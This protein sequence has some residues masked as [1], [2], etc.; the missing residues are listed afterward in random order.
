M[1]A[2]LSIADIRAL[3][4]VKIAVIGQGTQK[5][6]KHFGLKADF[7]PSVYDGE[8]LGRELAKVCPAGSRILIPRASLGNP[9]LTEA[10][11]KGGHAVDDVATYDTVYAASPVIDEKAVLDSGEIDFAVFT[12][13]S[14]VRGF[15]ASAEGADLAKVRAV[16]IGRQTCA[17]AQALGMT[18]WTAE[19][20][21]LE[22]LCDKLEEAAASLREE[23]DPLT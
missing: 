10:L 18:V 9:E 16:C 20:A 2:L 19:K 6:L 7:I 15:A 8:T 4:G 1:D 5:A 13:A 21:T 11:K 3:A 23:A 17:A 12:S 22:S 14:T